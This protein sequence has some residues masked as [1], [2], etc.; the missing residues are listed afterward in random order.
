MGEEVASAIRLLKK[1]KHAQQRAARAM[2]DDDR[3][4]PSRHRQFAHDAIAANGHV[5]ATVSHSGYGSPLAS[6]TS[7]AS[8]P[9]TA[10]VDSQLQLLR[11]KHTRSTSNLGTRSTTQGLA[12]APAEHST[13]PTVTPGTVAASASSPSLRRRP[14][15]SVVAEPKAAD[16]E[17]DD[18]V[19]HM[20]NPRSDTPPLTVSRPPTGSMEAADRLLVMSEQSISAL[21]VRVRAVP[22]LPHL[23]SL[24]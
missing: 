19:R 6:G 5:A 13:S 3:S 16:S 7:A 2:T 18:A 12:Q 21:Q 9:T 20:T 4:T 14:L 15:L 1:S 22:P 11:H 17:G 10:V 23:R 24:L 8:P